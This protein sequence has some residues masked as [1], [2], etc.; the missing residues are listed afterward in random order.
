MSREIV[1]L[2]QSF[3]SLQAAVIKELDSATV[4][5]P[6]LHKAVVSMYPDKAIPKSITVEMQAALCTRDLFTVIKRHGMWNYINYH[7]LECVV[8]RLVPQNDQLRKQFA[9]HKDNVAQF[10]QKTPIHSYIDSC[11][12]LASETTANVMPV[13]QF[14][15]DPAMFASL[16]LTLPL[17]SQSQRLSVIL[18][19]QNH[20]MKHFSFPHPTLLLGAVSRGSTVV[21]FHFPRVELER[22][23]SLANSSSRFFTQLNLQSVTIDNQ[24]QYRNESLALM[25]HE[26]QS[27]SIS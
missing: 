24:F 25:T 13:H 17:S 14:P 12:H 4:K 23:C 21:S 2:A 6:Q 3:E 19:L 27:T 1:T 9:V 18:Q 10:V 22:V 16:N 15:P 11:S 5:V 26:V 7:L 8:E 20:V